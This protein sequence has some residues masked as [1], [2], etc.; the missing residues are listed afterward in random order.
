MLPTNGIRPFEYGVGDNCAVEWMNWMRSFEI[1][2]K[3]TTSVSAGLQPD[4]CSI[5][6]YHAGPKVQQVYASLESAE[7]QRGEEEEVNH[8]PL[9][10]AYLLPDD[11]YQTMVK[12]LT[13]F[14]APKR[15]KTIE[16][17]IFRNMKQ[18]ESE[19]ISMFVMRLRQQAERCEYEERVDEF[20]KDQITEGCSSTDLRRKILQQKEGNLEEIL[21]IARIY[22]TVLEESKVLKP[23]GNPTS[24]TTNS[25]DVNKID[26]K[27]SLRKFG[28]N[29]N[30]NDLVLFCSRCGYKGHGSSDPKCPAK[31]KHC[32]KC[33]GR[34]HFAR[35]CLSKSDRQLNKPARRDFHTENPSA[36]KRF[37]SNE[38]V[39]LIDDHGDT[40]K[41]PANEDD[42]DVLCVSSPSSNANTIVCTIGGV[43]TKA[44]I[45]SG[46]KCNLIGENIWKWLKSMNIAAT[47]RLRGSDRSFI[48]YG[49]HELQ[50]RGTFNSNIIVGTEQTT[51]KFY[52]MEGEGKFLIGRDTAQDL[53]ILKLGPDVNT[54]DEQIEFSKI[55]GVT[56]D[57]PINKTVKPV[58][59]SYRRVPVPLEKLV[60]E[61]V[62]MLR[63]QG[64]VEKVVGPS[65]WVSPLVVVP[66]KDDVRICVDMRRA[67]QAVERENHPLPTFEDFLPHL[68][69]AQ[70]Y[71][72]ID[73]KNA[74]H[75]VE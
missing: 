47:D 46:C 26:S 27:R 60:N 19:N 59:Q 21:T 61:K 14:F 39:R 71:S 7:P 5:L 67:N 63:Q 30:N 69:S 75:Q 29:R 18:Y 64:I 17:H 22:E 43:E 28:S 32:N 9:A 74:F 37:K 1:F 13:D 49:G 24:L 58:A 44:I 57:I 70:I 15:N 10:G 45:D 8:G 72:K 73:V 23:N 48:G 36:A 4:W 11:P 65:K 20:L 62:E 40:D 55:K 3:A 52:V 54:I 6:L 66:R 33:G 53:G 41:N 51:A 25:D 38:N 56:V 12:K 68:G 50:V 2:R 31:G 34:D 16:R 35:K 42:D